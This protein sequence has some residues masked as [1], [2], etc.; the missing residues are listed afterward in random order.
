MQEELV[1]FSLAEWSGARSERQKRQKAD[2]CARAGPNPNPRET[3]RSHRSIE[4]FFDDCFRAVR[5]A[6]AAHGAIGDATA[7]ALLHGRG[8]Q[9][10]LGFGDFALERL[11]VGERGSLPSSSCVMRST[12]TSHSCHRGRM[13]TARDAQ[14]KYQRA[15]HA[16]RSLAGAER[17]GH[18]KTCIRTANAMNLAVRAVGAAQKSGPS[19]Q[20]LLSSWEMSRSRAV[21]L[22]VVTPE[23][24][25]RKATLARTAGMRAKRRRARSVHDGT[26][27]ETTRAMLLRQ[28]YLSQMEAGA[29]C[30]SARSR[31]TNADLGRDAGRGP[32]RCR[33]RLSGLADRPRAIEHLRLASRVSPPSRRALSPVDARQRLYWPGTIARRSVP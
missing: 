2:A 24:M 30:G 4:A 32:P 11:G 23:L 15:T 6:Y 9:R 3:A 7:D 1:A 14:G 12:M 33:A 10:L 28:L 26:V 8:A 13:P 29:F 17:H 25:L 22:E 20:R 18:R 19:V 31:R 27:D 16:G 5:V 21:A